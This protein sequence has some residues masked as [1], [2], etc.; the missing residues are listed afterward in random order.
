MAERLQKVLAQM[1]LGSRR[2]IE[3]W[4]R[5]GR[6]LVNGET[7]QLGVTV[8]A[9]DKIKVDGK[10]VSLARVATAQPRVII[11][12]KPEGEVCSKQDDQNRP[13]VFD[14]LPNLT[15]GRWVNIGRL[16]VNTS[17]LILFTT[18]GELANRLMH[19]SYQIEREYAV[20]VF[21]EVAED[22]IKLLTR[23]V[24]LED[25]VASFTRILDAGGQGRNHWYHVVLNEG[26]NRE[27]RR[28]WESQDVQVSRLIRLRYGPVEL[29]RDVR[30]GRWRDL[31]Y[32]EMR[33]LYQAVDLPAPEKS[34]P[35]SKK[36]VRKHKIPRK[37]R[38]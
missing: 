1:G 8:D 22:T 13:T 6:I 37:H 36:H 25:G 10:P 26:R 14:H 7:A 24:E 32:E 9:N 33:A 17:G 11:Y 21:G 38:T 16:D 28:L 20:R 15:Q 5:D 29:G 23:G 3:Q 2:A 31:A 35:K 27:V 19:P 12:N 18:D 30:Q 4:I 34:K